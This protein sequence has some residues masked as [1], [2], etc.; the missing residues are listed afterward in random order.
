[1][2]GT[3]QF[4]GTRP[5]RHRVAIALTALLALT[6]AACGGDD[7]DGGAATTADNTAAPATTTEDSGTPTTGADGGPT[8]S[9]G[10]EGTP[11]TGADTGDGS[12]PSAPGRDD[13]IAAAIETTASNPLAGTEGSGST[14]GVS[15]DTVKIGCIFEVANYAGFEEAITARFAEGP[16]N[17]R[18]LELVPCEDDAGDPANTLTIAKRLVEQEKVFGI[19][20]ATQGTTPA[21]STYLNENEVPYI[22]WGFTDAFCGKRWGFG[23]D[24]CLNGLFSDPAEVPQA[25]LNPYLVQPMVDNA[26]MDPSEVRAAIIGSDNDGGR[27]GNA[28]YS[29]LFEDLGATVVYAEAVVPVPGPTTDYTPFVQAALDKDPNVVLISTQFS[30]VGGLTAALKSAGFEGAIMNFVAYVPGLLDALPQL[31]EALEGTY[32]LASLVPQEQQNGYI[33][34]VEDSLEAA[35]TETGR[36]ITFG[37]SLGYLMGD[38]MSAM[39]EASGEQLDTA[40]FDAAVNGGDYTYTSPGEGGPCSLPYPGAH[41]FSASGS[42]LV[43][44]E[45]GKFSVVAPYTCYSPYEIER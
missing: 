6:A 25:F 14:R 12:T 35:G 39:I 36:F 17:G 24:G 11:T 31:A 26:G 43:K 19:I 33:K 2:T 9:A 42:A 32:V 28:N 45:G 34:I 21:L 8:T 29:R 4:S 23:F 7:D 37:G 15:D 30:D 3:G 18:T 38:Q 1:M 22:G 44:V 41:Y 5:R 16:I 40:T 27:A 10:D 20:T 13:A